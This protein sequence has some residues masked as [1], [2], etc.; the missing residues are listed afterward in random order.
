MSPFTSSIAASWS[1]VSSNG[2]AS[3]TS[4]C[5]G[6]S[7]ANAWPGVASRWRYS[8]TSSSAISCTALRTLARCRSKSAPPIRFSDGDSPPVYLRTNPTWSV[9]TYTLPSRNSSHR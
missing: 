5:Q 3:S 1:G 9:G 8:T 4:C 2:N 6:V 7:S